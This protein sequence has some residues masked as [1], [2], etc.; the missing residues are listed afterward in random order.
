M[1]NFP[2]WILLNEDDAELVRQLSGDFDGTGT[3]DEL[4]F[5]ALYDEIAGQPLYSRTLFI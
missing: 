5:S 4:G 1:L 2:G 3:V